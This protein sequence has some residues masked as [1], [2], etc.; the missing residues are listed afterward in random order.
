[1]HYRLTPE[2]PHFYPCLKGP[3]R[4]QLECQTCSNFH[5]HE[6]LQSPLTCCQGIYSLPIGATTCYDAFCSHQSHT[7]SSSNPSQHVPNFTACPQYRK[8]ILLS[9]T[10]LYRSIG[11]RFLQTSQA[12]K[13]R[14]L[15]Q[16]THLS[17]ALGLEINVDNP[18]SL[19]VTDMDDPAVLVRSIDVD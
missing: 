2:L 6:S 16:T 14:E 8:H 4:R 7:L 17:V 18:F 1:M 15:P 13:T 5:W 12:Q 9:F 19:V 11:V 3:L 10:V